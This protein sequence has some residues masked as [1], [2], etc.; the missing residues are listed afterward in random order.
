MFFLLGIIQ[1]YLIN[2]TNLGK[3]FEILFSIEEKKIF[4]KF[5]NFLHKS[6]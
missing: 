2:N 6:N 3:N 5:P 4:N 1:I